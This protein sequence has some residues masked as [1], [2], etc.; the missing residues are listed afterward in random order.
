MDQAPNKST[1]SYANTHRP[2]EMYR[3][4]FYRTLTV[5]RQA[6]PGHHS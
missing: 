5:C 6:G 2:W 4:L 1:L 3:D